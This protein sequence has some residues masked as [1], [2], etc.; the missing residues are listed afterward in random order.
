MTRFTDFGDAGTYTGD[1]VAGKRH[2]KGKMVYDS[3]NTYEGEFKDGGINGKGVYSWSDGDSQECSWVASKRHGPSIFYAANGEVEYSSYINDEATGSGVT[4]TADRTK[5]YKLVNGKKGDEISLGM[6]ENIAE[7]FGLEVPKKSDVKIQKRLPKS[8]LMTRMFASSYVDGNGNLRF[9]DY[10]SWGTYVGD[11]DD[12]GKREGK[13]KISYDQGGF[14]D[15]EFKNNKFEGNGTYV[16]DDGESYEGEWK[17]GERNG[18]AIFRSKDGTV[19][20]QMFEAGKPSGEGVSWT[21]D[22]KTAH[23]ITSDDK[24]L[25]MLLEEAEKFAMEKFNLP[26]P[27][28]SD[29]KVPPVQKSVGLFA[30]LFGSGPVFDKEGNPMFKDNGDWGTWSGEVDS[31][32]NR[33]GFGRMT[34]ES[35][36]VYEGCFMNN[37]YEDDTGKS[38]YTWSDGE[39]YLGQWKNGE[40][41]GKGVYYAKDGTVEYSM[42]EGG[43]AVGMGIKWSADRKSA[44]RLTDG[45]ETIEISYGVAQKESKEKFDLPV[46]EVSA[47]LTSPAQSDGKAS[48]PGLFQRIFKGAPPLDEEGNPMFRDNSDWCSYVGDRD[49]NGHRSGKGKCTYQSGAV[50]QGGFV[51]NKYEGEGTYTWDDGDKYEGQWKD[52][53]RNGKGTFYHSDGTVEIAIFEYGVTKG[54]GIHWSPDRKTAWKLVNG[55]KKMEMLPEEAEAFAKEKFDAPV[56]EVSMVDTSSATAAKPGLFARMWNKYDAD[57]NLMYKDNGDWGSWKGQLDSSGK[58]TSKGTMAYDGG[59]KFEGEFVN[60]KYEGY[61]TYTWSDGDSYEGEWKNG[62]RNGKGI[63][64]SGDGT[65]EYSMYDN[66]NPQGEGIAWA[67]DRKSAWKLVNGDKTVNLLVGEAEKLSKDKFDLPVPPYYKAFRE[68][69]SSSGGFFGFFT[70]KKQVT[71]QPSSQKSSTSTVESWLQSELPNLSASDLSTYSK[72]LIEDG[73]DSVDMLN[74]LEVGDLGFMKK[75]HQRVLVEKLKAKK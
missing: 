40:R 34:Y 4:W 21:A 56:P 24:K 50:Y 23:K 29:I 71:P 55:E 59:A 31:D 47:A 69:A 7:E 72:Q 13:G 46:P 60:D 19:Q 1:L 6:A 43:H 51:N 8:G 48:Q 35:G 45:K 27:E 11:I 20:Y 25:E 73:F 70:S 58:R 36:S 26:V 22:R 52:G 41:E 28:V 30:R 74:H 37:V 14:Y 64:R 68:P 18:K 16:W 54:E 44:F 65:V 12:A 10:G 39:Y 42:Y 62:E 49:A 61:G 38:K 63:F 57:G 67:P 17:D 2:G 32:T 66:G 5:A 53:E 3:G 15:G 75:A 33:K 9:K